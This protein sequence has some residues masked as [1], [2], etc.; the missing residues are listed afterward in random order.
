MTPKAIRTAL[1]RIARADPHVSVALDQVGYPAPRN[2]QPGFASLLDIILGQQ[3]SVHAAAAIRGRL[4]DAVQPLTPASFLAADDDTLRTVGLSRRKIEYGRGLAQ[5][6]AEGRLA[7]KDL[8]VLDDEAAIAEITAVRGLGRWSAEIYLLFA[9]RRADVWPADDLAIRE[10]LK[11]LKG[12]ED[13]PDRAASEALVE[14]WRPHR[15]IG[16]LF[17]WHYYKGAP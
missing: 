17:L 9:M 11:R 4:A 10:A 2:R 8:D 14:A 5:A 6:M 3:V 13:R 12:L 7:L 1:D 15:G 16:A